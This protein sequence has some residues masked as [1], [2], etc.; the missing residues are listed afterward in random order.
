MATKNHQHLNIPE[1]EG[2]L[3]LSPIRLG[4]GSRI[5]QSSQKPSGESE[6]SVAQTIEVHIDAVTSAI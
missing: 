2:N 6:T 5:A 1:T 3:T 4:V